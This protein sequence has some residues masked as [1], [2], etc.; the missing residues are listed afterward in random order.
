MHPV[1]ESLRNTDRQ[2]LIDTLYAFNS[3]NVERFQTLKTAWGQQVSH[4]RGWRSPRVELVCL[5]SVER[6]PSTRH[7]ALIEQ[8][9]R[10]LMRC[11]GSSVTVASV[12]VVAR[13]LWPRL[14]WPRLLWPRSGP[15]AERASPVLGGG[16]S[17][18][19][20]PEQDCSVCDLRNEWEVAS[21][22]YGR[23]CLAGGEEAL[24]VSAK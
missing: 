21:D 22:E 23:A 17:P 4:R 7:F 19:A 14:L 8:V 1:L 2:W 6:L 13:L 15:Q 9:A 16:V 18:E 20:S 11:C 10:S 3:G 12:T 24:S 5:P